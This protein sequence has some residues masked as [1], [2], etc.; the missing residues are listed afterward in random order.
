M[1]ILIFPTYEYVRHDI[2][3]FPAQMHT[4]IPYTSTSSIYD[5]YHVVNA[6]M[7]TISLIVSIHEW[8]VFNIPFI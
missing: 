2:P 5:E 7:L 1:S 6:V 3:L 8:L 4:H